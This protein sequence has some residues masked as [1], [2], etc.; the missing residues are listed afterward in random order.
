M[1]GW[2]EQLQNRDGMAAPFYAATG[3]K[4]G[5]VY[6]NLH[7]CRSILALSH[8]I[9]PRSGARL[10]SERDANEKRWQ[11]W[12]LNDRASDAPDALCRIGRRLFR[13]ERQTPSDDGLRMASTLRP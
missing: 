6:P 8:R 11:G 13:A 10:Q 1:F 3:R 5:A 12:R 7:I 4:K 2:P 9:P